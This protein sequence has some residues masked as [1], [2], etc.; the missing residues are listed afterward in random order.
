MSEIAGRPFN[1]DSVSVTELHPP[2]RSPSS[3]V[4]PAGMKVNAR[5]QLLGTGRQVE[6][7]CLASLV[8]FVRVSSFTIA[9]VDAGCSL[10]GPD[11]SDPTAHS[12]D[13]TA[14]SYD[15][16][17]PCSALPVMIVC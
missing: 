8:L 12:D 13:G 7:S 5:R 6:S 9:L 11:R 4:V 17:I 1:H 16:N 3:L 10:S 15:D 14:S 2:V